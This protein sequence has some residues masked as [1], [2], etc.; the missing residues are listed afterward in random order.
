LNPIHSDQIRTSGQL[1]SQLQ[2]LDF[3]VTKWDWRF[4]FN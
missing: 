1:S 4:Q 3:T 2:N